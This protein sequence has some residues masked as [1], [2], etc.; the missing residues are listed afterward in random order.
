MIGRQRES[1]KKRERERERER[2]RE[3]ERD[4][5]RVQGKFEECQHI[6]WKAV[7]RIEGDGKCFA[8]ERSIGGEGRGGEGR[9]EEELEKSRR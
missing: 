6:W 9:R 1:D 8:R 2:R 7:V 5:Y 3:R 4:R